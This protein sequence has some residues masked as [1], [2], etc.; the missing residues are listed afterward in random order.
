MS[1]IVENPILN[2]FAKVYNTLFVLWCLT[3]DKSYMLAMCQLL[4]P[5]MKLLGG[6]I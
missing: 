6:R 1:A 4:S 2:A 5:V 3:A